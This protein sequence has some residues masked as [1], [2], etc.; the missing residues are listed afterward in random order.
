MLPPLPHRRIRLAPSF[1]LSIV[2]NVS[3]AT[4][5]RYAVHDDAG[6]VMDTVKI[7]QDATGGYLAVSHHLAADGHFRSTSPPR[8]TS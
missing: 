4:G 2:E 3:G 8:P 7:I 6:H 5:K 1:D